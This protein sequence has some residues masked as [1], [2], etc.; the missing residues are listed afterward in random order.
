MLY[1]VNQFAVAPDQPGGTRH[2]EMSRELIRMGI[3]T[4]VVASDLN[5]SRR[6]YLCRES[7]RDRR[8]LRGDADGV[9]FVWL[10][11]GHYQAND[12]R[13]ALSMTVFSLHVLWFLL[14]APMPAGSVIIGSSPHLLAAA[15]ARVAAFV[16]LTPFVLEVRDLWPESL[17][18]AGRRGPMYW[19][20]RKI[21]DTLYRTSPSIIV[22]AAGNADRVAARGVP[23]ERIHYVPNGVDPSVFEGAEPM[24]LPEVPPNRQVFVYAGAHGPANDLHTVLDAAELLQDH[25]GD[26]AHVLLVGDGPSKAHLVASARRRGLD[27]V[28]FLDP[29]PKAEIPG[30][31]KSCA[32]GIMPLADV[33]LFSYGVSPN[34]LFD[35]LSAGL[36]VITNVPG[37]VARMVRE[38]GAGIVVPPADAGA[39]ADAMIQVLETESLASG[40]A[41]IREH[42]DRATLA[43]QLARALSVARATSG[44]VP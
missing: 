34:K 33:E 39:L 7:P 32:A 40:L 16:R 25:E 6:A 24:P 42:H 27:N 2:F 3:A 41:W 31:L 17:D 12:W 20:L 23:H 9:P 36:P 38:A 8:H 37:D 26:K 29:V 18:V 14:R 11:A 1:W 35:Y 30:L 10:P 43:R 15:A 44:R 21:A 19:L 28:T 13:R 5:L 22:L 4:T